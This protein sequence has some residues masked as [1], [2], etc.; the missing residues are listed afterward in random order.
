VHVADE[1]RDLVALV[2]PGRRQ[3][4]PEEGIEQEAGGDHRHDPA[5]RA[6]HR[7]EHQHDQRD[8]EEHVPVVRRDR[9]VEE[10]VALDHEVGAD[11]GGRL[12]DAGDFFAHGMSGAGLT[13]RN[14]GK[15]FAYLRLM[16]FSAKYFTAPG[17]QGTGEASFFWFSSLMFSASLCVR[18]RSSLWSNTA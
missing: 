13:P 9:A 8:T 12:M 15:R 5:G 11:L 3:I 6:A 16:P 1:A 17:C 4:R 7:L 2:R 10:I 18:T 14:S